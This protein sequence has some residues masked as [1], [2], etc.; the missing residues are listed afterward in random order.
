MKTKSLAATLIGLFAV[1][2][3]AGATLQSRLSANNQ[4]KSK[5]T[6]ETAVRAIN[7]KGSFSTDQ[8]SFDGEWWRAIGPEQQAGFVDG[9]YDC[10]S[11]DAK[12]PNTA[13]GSIVEFQ[14]AVSDFYDAHQDQLR[15]SVP[16]V[17]RDLA[18]SYKSPRVPLKGGEVW[19][20]PH[21]YY[22]G[23]WW[24]QSEPK[25]QI[26]YLEGYLRCY[27]HD[28]P[29]PPAQ[30]SNRPTEYQELITRYYNNPKHSEDKKIAD[31]LYHFRDAQAAR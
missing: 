2:V 24:K 16:A 30:F 14:K 23:L 29:Q 5:L 27:S 18:V 11:Y 1:F 22:D 4:P 26:G 20:E 15:T 10:Y 31:V 12:G 13:T 28:L 19:N 3:L 21:G 6:E 17:L 9:Y 8:T 7:A 25:E